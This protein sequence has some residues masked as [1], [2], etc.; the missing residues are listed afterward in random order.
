MSLSLRALLR[1]TRWSILVDEM[2]RYL[3]IIIIVKKR[4]TLNSPIWNDSWQTEA[5]MS[6][7]SNCGILSPFPIITGFIVFHSKRSSSMVLETVEQNVK[8]SIFTGLPDEN[9]LL[10]GVQERSWIPWELRFHL[11]TL[12]HCYYGKDATVLHSDLKLK[13]FHAP[14]RKPI[15]AF[16]WITVIIT[17][18]LFE[19]KCYQIG[20]VVAGNYVLYW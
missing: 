5:E 6:T 9:H 3:Q 13:P 7:I 4:D 1:Q 12:H 20:P 14:V 18:V 10:Q 11:V 15:N 17:E 2:Y 16:F 19:L 8:L